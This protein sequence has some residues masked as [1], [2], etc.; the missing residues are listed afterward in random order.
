MSLLPNAR[1][2]TILGLGAAALLIGS[3]VGSDGPTDPSDSAIVS[4]A[5]QPAL[6]PSPADGNALPIHRIRTT[7]ARASG[8]GVLRE[9]SFDVSPTD[10]SWTLD[11]EVP[12]SRTPVDVVLYMYLNHIATDGTESTQFSGRSLPVAATAGVTLTNV[13]VD[14]VRGPLSNLSVTGVSIGAFPDTL[15]VGSSGTISATTTSSDSSTPQLFWTSSNP[16]VLTLADS[17]A[18]AASP[19]TANVIASAGAFADTVSIVVIVPPVATV[20]VLPDSADVVVNGTRTYTVELRDAGNNVL[21]G[22][23]VL[24]STANPS[25]ATVTQAGVVNAVGVGATTV[26]ATSEGRLDDAVVR[27]VNVPVRAV[28]V[29]PDS[30]VVQAGNTTAFTAVTR[31]SIGGV[32]TG[33]VVTWSTGSPAIASV[34]GSGVVTGVAAGTTT[35]TA[36]S[37]GVSDNATVRVTSV[38][39]AGGGITWT[40]IRSGNWSDPTGWSLG[41]ILQAGDTVYL[42][43]NDDHTITLDVNATVARLVIGG[44]VDLIGLN[45]GNNVLTV[46]NDIDV[47]P[48]GQ[49]QVN[50]GTVSANVILNDGTVR[51]LGSSTFN[52]DIENY[53]DWRISGLNASMTMTKV[54]GGY[55]YNEA[56]LSIDTTAVLNM[57]PA[58]FLEFAGGT[59][60]YS[61]AGVTLIGLGG[62]L[63]LDQDLTIDGPHVIIADGEID[64]F[65]LSRLTIGPQSVIQMVSTAQQGVVYPT[66]E[67]QGAFF[68]S[69]PDMIMDDSLIVAV[70]GIVAV[71]G[72]S[73]PTELETEIVVNDGIILL[74]G[75]DSVTFGPGGAARSFINRS[76]GIIQLAPGGERV[77]NGEL[78]N[79]GEIVVAGPTTLQRGLPGG[80]SHVT[81]NH[82]NSGLI[83]LIAGGSFDV[84]L[85][86][87][88]PTFTNA[89]SILVGAGSTLSVSNLAGPAGSIINASTGVLAGDGT[90]DVRSG[91]P[92]GVNN[93]VIAPGQFGVGMLTWLGAIPMGPT[94]R[95]E[96]E[97][98]GISAG[99]QYDQLNASFN[100]VL[101]AF[102]PTNGI[103]DV[104]APFYTPAPGERYAVL[105]FAQR[106]GNFAQV[107]LP[108]FAG[109]V[110]DTVWVTTPSTSVADTLVIVA[111]GG[112]SWDFEADFSYTSPTFNAWTV[113][114]RT[115]TGPFVPVL[116]ADSG[117]AG[118]LFN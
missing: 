70:G 32:L 58:G 5:V 42:T 113:G 45:I 26:R 67:V 102:G 84:V 100:L 86:G 35:V 60:S 93:G 106:L 40:A 15:F 77:L 21:T 65:A 51:I 115:A 2:R 49:L 56:A 117:S 37:E 92:S 62:K 81:A 64:E 24:W 66:L 59:A 71:D 63:I 103:L 79:Q 112:P 85:G 95:I 104:T 109:V 33:R 68:V 73:G 4:I 44:T 43:Q 114:S 20:R 53:D 69:G 96:I 9:Q 57:G 82:V 90:V 36:T 61:D 25:V 55:F 54:G 76:G 97:L 10:A 6:I 17:V 52:A 19:G 91:V 72:S 7:A 74:S 75:A 28:L 46:T 80:T 13:N 99:S 39:T 78:I 3:C 83:E 11:I 1:S 30:A 87:V 29:S 105:T 12:A 47:R 34:N 41:R 18:T 111:S 23:A 107:N 108:T 31:D 89:D 48:L 8:G 14:I 38:P 88:S 16:A 110:L 116:P 27:V 101:D 50:S 98:D 94:G 118:D 22:R